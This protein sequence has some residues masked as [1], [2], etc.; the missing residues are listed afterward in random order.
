MKKYTLLLACLLALTVRAETLK[1][2]WVGN[3]LTGAMPK[4]LMDVV[5]KNPTNARI[6]SIMST[7]GGADWSFHLGKPVDEVRNGKTPGL[8][9]SCLEEKGRFDWVVIQTVPFPNEKYRFQE[10]GN[11]V[12]EKIRAAGAE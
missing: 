8:M 9:L 10:F 6:T 4:L 7:A 2:L 12:I 5:N 3:S 11:E 1:V